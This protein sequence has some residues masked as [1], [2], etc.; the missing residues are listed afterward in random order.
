M[1]VRFG[2]RVFASSW[3]LT[4]LAALLC[5]VFVFL[6]RWQWVRG[7][8]RQQAWDL[9]SR[10]TGEV[11]PLGSRPLSEIHLFQRVSVVGRFDEAHQFLLDN[12]SYAG[13]PGYEV[14]T[15][16]VRA[17]GDVA[18]I[19]RGWVPFSGLRERLP[20][21]AIKSHDQITVTGRVADLPSAGLAS[22]RAA[23]SNQAPWPK[24]TSFPTMGQLRQAFGGPLDARILLLDARD[25]DGYVRQWHPPGLE[26]TRHWSYAIQWWIFAAVVLFLW[27]R[28]SLRRVPEERP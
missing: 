18:L 6:G 15:P 23:P 22:G 4:V 7:N 24:V 17:G 27:V 19:D 20:G 28:L 13:R 3:G 1:E 26:P 11:I 10:G 12:R 16:L 8:V 25:P 5:G 14:L 9:F 2:R 21:V